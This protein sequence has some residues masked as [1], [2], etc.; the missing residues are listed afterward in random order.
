ML[1]TYASTRETILSAFE[2]LNRLAADRGAKGV[3]ASSSDAEDRLEKNRFNLVV[4]GEFKR[5]K[6]TFVNAL[7]GRDLLPRAVVPL[8]SIVTLVRYDAH[9]KA[10]VTFLDG[11]RLETPLEDLPAYITE[12]AN[13]RNEKKVARVEVLLPSPLLKDGVQLVDTPGVGSVYEHNTDVTTEF[14][15][16]ADAAIFLVAADPPISKSE[17]EFLRQ[18]RHYVARVFFVQNKIDHLSPEELTQSLAFNRRVIEEELGHDSVRVFPVSARLALEGKS[19]GDGA[20]TSSSN[21]HEFERALGD[22]LMRERGLVA[23]QSAA[24]GAIKAASDLRVSIE[25]E[26]RAVQTPVETLQERLSLFQERLGVVRDKK[27]EDLFLL[28]KLLNQRVVELLDSDLEALQQSQR[29]PLRERLQEAADAAAD[30]TAARMLAD[31]NAQLP[32]MVEDILVPWQVSESERLTK[33][34]DERLQPF[35]DKV[36]SLIDQVHT[37]SAEVFDVNV[38]HF[39]PDHRLAGF[40]SFFVRNWQIQVHFELAAMPALYALPARWIRSRIVNAAWA[41]LWEQFGMHCGQLRYDFVRR[42]QESIEEYSRMLDAKVEDTADSIAAA[43]RAA[44]EEQQRGSQAVAEALE[45][46]D[47]QKA[48]VDAVLNACLKIRDHL[49]GGSPDGSGPSE[50]GH[51]SA[52]QGGSGGEAAHQALGVGAPTA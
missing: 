24:N 51:L 36:N 11:R 25:L 39:A 30:K 7:L 31:I 46:L 26:R 42:L 3:L 14:M 21:I 49:S 23:L 12:E 13:P 33:A 40:S 50:D 9:E 15:P 28:R 52:E 34:L 17:R 27:E 45:R 1:D 32:G 19:R 22:F 41:R 38:E 6:S 29:G 18:V 8:T 48:E 20:A 10:V 47:R 35:T 44:I 16:S 37:I 5:G 4:F 43:V 2:T